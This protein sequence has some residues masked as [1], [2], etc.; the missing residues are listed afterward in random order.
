MSQNLHRN[1][2]AEWVMW[3]ASWPVAMI[4]RLSLAG[5]LAGRFLD[6]AASRGGPAKL[7]STKKIS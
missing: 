5:P 1:N 4:L 2:A 6:R 3:A 7:G